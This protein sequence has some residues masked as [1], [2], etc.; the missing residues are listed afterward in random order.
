[1]NESVTWIGVRVGTEEDAQARFVVDGLTAGILTTGLDAIGQHQSARL[2]VEHVGRCGVDVAGN[3]L[4]GDGIIRAW[5]SGQC[6]WIERRSSSCGCR[7][8]GSCRCVRVLRVGN[9]GRN[10]WAGQ[11]QQQRHAKCGGRPQGD[12]LTSL[13]RHLDESLFAAYEKIHLLLEADE[14]ISLLGG[15]SFHRRHVLFTGGQQFL[16]DRQRLSY[17]S[18]HSCCAVDE[19]KRH[20][21]RTHFGL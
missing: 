5:S 18:H 4:E 2:R 13:S 17:G 21:P 20:F 19:Q 11:A 12:H 6:G 10:P 8:V 9:L 7:S 3:Q 15:F 14:L 1:M 16:A